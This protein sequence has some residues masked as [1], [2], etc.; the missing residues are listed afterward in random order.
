MSI[1]NWFKRKE[2]PSL[3]SGGNGES[4]ETAVVVNTDNSFA[5]VMAECAYVASVC[6][7][8]EADWKMKSQSLQKHNGK[9]Y[10]VLNV[11]LSNGKDRSFYFDISK[12][13]GR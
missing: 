8:P 10:D 13:F 6:G 4:F 3:F 5:G 9:P 2:E 11:I 12:F 1:F 7:R